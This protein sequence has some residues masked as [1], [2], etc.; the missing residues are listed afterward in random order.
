MMLTQIS[1]PVCAVNDEGQGPTAGRGPAKPVA[2]SADVKAP[3]AHLRNRSAV[4][5]APKHV[6]KG[7]LQI[8]LAIFHQR[9]SRHDLPTAVGDL[10]IVNESL[11]FGHREKWTGRIHAAA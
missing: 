4:I 9:G 1:L 11:R 8:V 7:D 2:S 10:W 3:C 5:E 6:V